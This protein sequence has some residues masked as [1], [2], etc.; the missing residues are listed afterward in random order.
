MAKM[1]KDVWLYKYADEVRRRL[2]RCKKRPTWQHWPAGHMRY[3][4]G[5]TPAKAAKM[6]LAE[7]SFGRQKCAIRR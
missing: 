3:A 5:M 2:K 4:D 1:T 7:T 6:Y